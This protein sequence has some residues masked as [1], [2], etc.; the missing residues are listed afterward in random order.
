LPNHLN[1]PRWIHPEKICL[2]YGLPVRV[3]KR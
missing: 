2:L 3:T 1:V